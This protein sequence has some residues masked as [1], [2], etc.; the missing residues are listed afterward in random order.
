MSFKR[1]HLDIFIFPSFPNQVI[2]NRLCIYITCPE[3]DSAIR[4]FGKCRIVGF[5]IALTNH[6]ACDNE[7][8]FWED[9]EDKKMVKNKRIKIPSRFSLPSSST[10]LSSASETAQSF[11]DQP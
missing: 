6:P 3:A 9:N 4:A 2:I 1:T 11:I 10:S 5:Q 8:T 7:F